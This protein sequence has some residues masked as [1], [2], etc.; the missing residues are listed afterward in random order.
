M[1]NKLIVLTTVNMILALTSA[2]QIISFDH[3]PGINQIGEKL[4]MDQYEVSNIA[5][6]EYQHWTKIIFGLNSDEY[7]KTQIDSSIVTNEYL[8]NPVYHEYPVI[9]ISYDQASSF[10]KW[11]SDRVYEMTLIKNKLVKKNRNQNKDSYFSLENIKN[12]K[13]K[14]K[15]PEKLKSI[16][17]P[18]YRLPSSAEWEY[19]A[20]GDKDIEIFLNSSESVIYI[21]D[22][23]NPGLVKVNESEVLPPNKYNLVNM[24]GNVS[25]IVSEKGLAKGGN[26]K[27]K[28]DEL[29]IKNSVLYT[30]PSEWLGFR[31]LC[32]FISP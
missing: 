12:G 25:E 31:C 2:G 16:K 30:L 19:A 17:Y 24:F 14:I 23:K 13:Y 1:K 15:K 9:G 5:F 10:C 18:Q 29:S 7:K 22:L 28:L 26:W 32:E 11:R 21:R 8:N 20:L 27:T 4:Y 6:L 3:P